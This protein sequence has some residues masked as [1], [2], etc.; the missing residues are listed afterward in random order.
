MCPAAAIN[1]LLA[2]YQKNKKKKHLG[3]QL[4]LEAPASFSV[5]AKEI[6]G[7]YV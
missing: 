5:W 4:I 1:K 7:M 2:F 3:T 6:Y